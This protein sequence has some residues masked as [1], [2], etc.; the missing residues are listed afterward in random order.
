MPKFM[1]IVKGSENHTAPPPALFAAIDQLMKDAGPR[2]VGVGGL[3]G[4]AKGARARLSKGKVK[5][6]DGPFTEAKE[7][8]GGF[9]IYD[10]PTLEEAKEWTR[11]FLDVHIKHFPSWDCEVEIRQ[12]MDDPPP[13]KT[14]GKGGLSR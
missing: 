8:I 10:V 1:T 5:V 7:V 3:L 4:S 14:A 11:R 13:T 12:M 6:T 9:A 2:L